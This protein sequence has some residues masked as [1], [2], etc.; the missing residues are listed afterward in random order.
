MSDVEEGQKVPMST[1]LTRLSWLLLVC[2]SITPRML[3]IVLM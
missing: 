1:A 3:I 2:T